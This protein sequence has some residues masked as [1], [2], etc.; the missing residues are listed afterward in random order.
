MTIHYYKIKNCYLGESCGRHVIFP[1]KDTDRKTLAK[2]GFVQLT[3]SEEWGHFLSDEEYQYIMRFS[4]EEDVTFEGCKYD[5]QNTEIIADIN[6]KYKKSKDKR[7]KTAKTLS[8]L[9]TILMIIALVGSSIDFFDDFKISIIF[10][11][12]YI[13]SVVLAIALR[14]IFPENMSG[15]VLIRSYTILYVIFFVI[16]MIVLIVAVHS[17]MNSCNDFLV[18]CARMG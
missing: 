10:F 7:N 1:P 18:G 11:L 4:A 2:Y 12:L 6:G 17:C 16:F 14:I 9:S 15:K 13:V 8:T 5:V 3:D